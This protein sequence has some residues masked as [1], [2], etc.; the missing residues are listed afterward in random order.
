MSERP[1]E[2][3]SGIKVLSLTQFLLGPA[4]VQYLADLGAD[5]I[6]IE[7]PGIGAWE[8]SWSGA[9]TFLNGVS[10][11]Y[12]LSHRNVRSVTLNLKHQ[13]AQ[14]VAGR[15][16]AQA[17]VIVENFRPGVLEGFGLGY[18]D[19]RHINPSIIYASCSG[20]GQDSPY[21]DLPGQDLLVQA[22]SGLAAVTGQ[23]SQPPTPAGAAIVDQHGAAL[24]AM[25]VLAALFHRQRT[26]E[27]QKIDI[28]MLH[29]AL[30]LQ[31]EPFLYY[32]NGGVVQRPREALASSF[33]Q[34]P[35]GIY[36]TRDGYLALSLSPIKAIRNALGGPSELEPYDDPK[37]VLEKREEIHQALSRFISTRTTDEWLAVLRP[38]G[39]WCAAVNDY[40]HVLQDAAIRHLDPLLEID[41]PQAGKAWLLKHPVRYSGGEPELRRMPP[42]LGEHTEEVLE[43][44]GYSGEE[45]HR[46]RAAGSI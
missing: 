30:D 24:L 46:L 2:I 42:A 36:E 7:T 41:H 1:L 35:Y 33:H 5:V 32:V 10:V 43:E 31:L 28:V 12:L 21:R 39:I 23:E 16:I 13:E 18:E 15:L 38:H 20:Y 25:G 34:A 19:A 14:G 9:D 6:K 26:G 45:I 8:R 17:D 22:M 4:G 29:A 27:G 11:F 44:L 40:E 37:V 3:L